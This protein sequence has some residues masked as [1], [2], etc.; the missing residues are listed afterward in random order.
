MHSERRYARLLQEHFEV[1]F[2]HL[3]EK[4]KAEKAYKPAEMR[5]ATSLLETSMYSR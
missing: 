3:D 1:G 4:T 2:T 5:M